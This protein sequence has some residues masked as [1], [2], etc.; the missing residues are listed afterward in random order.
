MSD[1]V[2]GIDLGTS[3]TSVS[4]VQDGMATVIPI[5]GEEEDK[6]M[7]SV[8]GFSNRGETIT[9]GKKAKDLR[10]LNPVNTIYS[11]KRVIGR[12][13]SHPE[14]QKYARRF[15]YKVVQGKNDSVEIEIFGRR[16]TPQMILSLVLKKA[17]KAAREYLGEEVNDAII[18]VPANYNEAQRRATQEAGRLAGLNV[19]RIINEPTAAALAYG[20][21]ANRNEKIA[22]LD[23][24]GGTFDI[25]ILEVNNNIF[26]VLAPPAT[27]SSAETISMRRL[28]SS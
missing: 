19:L 11:I 12:N 5:I 20:F 24:G 9:V 10:H 23:F 28:S 6:V 4:V 18:T 27:V 2:L 14:T 25:T 7:P 15:P 8:V 1:Y 3:T 13:F 21:G 16:V 17:K 26:S 22:V